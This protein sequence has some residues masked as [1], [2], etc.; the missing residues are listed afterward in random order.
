[1]GRARTGQRTPAL[2]RLGQ[3]GWTPWC[4]V[5]TEMLVW[6]QHCAELSPLPLG[7]SPA[8]TLQEGRRGA[9]VCPGQRCPAAARPSWGGSLL[10]ALAGL[11]QTGCWAPIRSPPP[12]CLCGEQEWLCTMLQSVAGS[13][14]QP[15]GPPRCIAGRERL[16]FVRLIHFISRRIQC[17]FALFSLS[18]KMKTEDAAVHIK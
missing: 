5:P 17:A 18:C 15:A 11:M 9:E 12:R 6:A 16:W 7:Q 13:S 14:C 1:M 3:A 8:G 10:L 2:A 4:R